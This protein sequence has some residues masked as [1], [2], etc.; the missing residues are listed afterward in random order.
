MTVVCF[1][2]GQF[3]SSV[4]LPRNTVLRVGRERGGHQDIPDSRE[5][6]GTMAYSDLRDIKEVEVTGDPVDRQALG[7]LRASLVYQGC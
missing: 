2:W 5:R 3:K 6:R 1:S 7:A 4:L